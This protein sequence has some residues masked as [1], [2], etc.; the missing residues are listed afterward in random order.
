M[1]KKQHLLAMALC[2]GALST[3][4]MGCELIASV[5]RSRIPGD[6]DVPNDGCSDGTKN[7][8]ETDVDCGGSIC[9]KCD[10]AK[11]CT[12]ATDCTSGF[13]A[14]GVCCDEACDAECDSCTAALKA[15][16]D[17]GEC[18]PSKAE[19]EC[20]EATCS[21]GVETSRGTCDGENVE[22]GPGEEKE[23]EEFAC[24]E[25][26]NACFTECME[27]AHCAKC[28]E[29]ADGACVLAAAGAE[30]LGC[31]EGQACDAA[32][33]CKPANGVECTEASACA[34][35]LCVDGVCCDTACDTACMACNV[36][37]LEGT[38]SNI[39]LGTEDEADCSGIN[40]CDGK[41]AC[42]LVGGEE[43]TTNEQCASGKCLPSP[44]FRCDEIP[45][46]P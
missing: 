9:P 29:C 45:E 10:A 7:N 21:E 31:D 12:A 16:G 25:A 43:C 4:G 28:H 11:A 30:G 27:D 24:N 38:C 44:L 40:T 41:G 46:T 20:G 33:E 42:K 14:D 8:E 36:K 22:C 3:L 17:D 13:C 15:S 18:G 1:W 6:E 35:G 32:G 2:A 5:D 23:C 37:D 26:A 39:P 19:T 34:T